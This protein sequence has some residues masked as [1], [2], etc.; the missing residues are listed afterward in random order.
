MEIVKRIKSGITTACGVGLVL[1]VTN[2]SSF[3]TVAMEKKVSGYSPENAAAL[4]SLHAVPILYDFG[5]ELGH[6]TFYGGKN[7]VKT[8]EQVTGHRNMIPRPYLD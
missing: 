3:S 1:L 7:F 4:N 6:R 8:A 5:F 2:G